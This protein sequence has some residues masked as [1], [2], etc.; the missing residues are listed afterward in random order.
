MTATGQTAA[1]IQARR[2]SADAMLQRVTRVL[3]Q[4]ARERAPVTV[5]G[6][7][8]R[9]GVS[10]TFLYQN[11]RAR[12]LLAAAAGQHA[13][14]SAASGPDATT[15]RAEASWRERG[16]NAE[17]Q[18]SRA[19]QEITVQRHQISDLLGRVRDLEHDLPEDGVQR[20]LTENHALRAQARQLTQDNHRLGERLAGARDTS[21]FL[22]KRIAQL[23]AEIAEHMALAGASR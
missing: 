5:A 8:R 10:R 2:A 1:A 3:A 7:G 18:L 16:L 22:D 21:R 9:A 19:H 14:S 23:E 15:A 13:G 6:V 4:V 20:V 12:A 11:E 17:H